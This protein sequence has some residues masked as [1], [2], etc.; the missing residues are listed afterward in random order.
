LPRPGVIPSSGVPCQ[1]HSLSLDRSCVFGPSGPSRGMSQRG[2]AEQ[3]HR[4]A[5]SCLLPSGIAVGLQLRKGYLAQRC[6]CPPMMLTCRFKRLAIF[7]R[8][9]QHPRPADRVNLSAY[10]QR[11]RPPPGADRV[12]KQAMSPVTPGRPG[13]CSLLVSD[14]A[15]CP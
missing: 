10:Q 14:R 8:A 11:F 7:A 13:C 12:R 3:A 6:G 2:K 5:C 1:M 4:S 9:V 15:D